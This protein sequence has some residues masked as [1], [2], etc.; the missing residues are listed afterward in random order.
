[1]HPQPELLQ[2][3]LQPDGTE[4]HLT[5]VSDPPQRLFAEYPDSR[6]ARLRGGSTFYCDN[7]VVYPLWVTANPE[8]SK[9]LETSKWRAGTRLAASRPGS[10][11]EAGIEVWVLCVPD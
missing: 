7:N 11:H 3:G 10:A 6:N 8:G 9:G 2:P 1:V 4:M 5:L